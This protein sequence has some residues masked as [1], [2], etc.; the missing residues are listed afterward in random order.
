MTN[1]PVPPKD[2]PI[3]VWIEYVNNA[4]EINAKE[5]TD[6]ELILCKEKTE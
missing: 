2:A 3:D 5:L 1:P 4:K 6:K